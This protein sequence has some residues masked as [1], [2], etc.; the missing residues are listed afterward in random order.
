[1]RSVDYG[2]ADRIVT[3]L[4]AEHG[5]VSALARAAR[6]SKRR[7]AGSL[8]GFAW[9]SVELSFG[10][11]ALATLVSARVTRSF[12]RLLGDLQ[13]LQAAGVLLRLARDLVPERVPE[14]IVYEALA[15]ML[16]ALDEPDMPPKR[17]QVAAQAQLLS[18]TGYAPLLTACAICGKVPGDGRPAL[19]DPE[20]GGLI[21]RACGGGPE[22][23]SFGLRSR[24][25]AALE[26]DLR[27]A[28]AA[29][30]TDVELREAERLLTLFVQHVLPKNT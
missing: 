4:T 3:L 6:K 26:G 25:L 19:F 24:L 30:W 17:L 28:A 14:P 11:G 9:V 13:R 10:R 8:E 1:L 23:L 12:P 15:D 21:C 5:R 29:D 7:F 16:V 2:E 22:R 27:E 18:M 20:R